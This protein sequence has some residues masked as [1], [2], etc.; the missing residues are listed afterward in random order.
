M[1]I[2]MHVL[3]KFRKY[4]VCSRFVVKT[5]HNSLKYFLGQCD[6][7]DRQQ[8]KWVNKLQVYDFEIE[9]MK[10]KKNTITDAVSRTPSFHYVSIFFADCKA[11]IMAKYVKIF[12]HLKYL[13]DNI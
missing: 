8:Q 5:D 10:G 3:S 9:F 2:V 6:L 13:M 7:N 12:L 1:L 11:Q 4:L